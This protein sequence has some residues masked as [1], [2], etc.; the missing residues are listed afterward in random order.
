MSIPQKPVSSQW[1]DVA[2]FRILQEKGDKEQYVCASGITP[3]GTVHIGNFREIISVDL[4]VRALRN[5]GKKVRFIYSW[6]E[7]DVFR[8]VPKN[9]PDPQKLEKYLRWPITLVP[10]PWG[11]EDSYARAHEKEVE[12]LLPLVGIEPEFIYQAKEYN[13]CRYAEG[14]KKALEKREVIMKILNQYRK[15]PLASDWQPVSIFCSSC[16]RDTTSVSDWDGEYGLSYSCQS[17][18][19][20]EIMDFRKQGNVKLLWRIDWPMRWREEQV[21][22]EPAGKDHHSEGGSFDTAKQ[23]VKEVYDWQPPAT[24][25]YDFISIKGRGGKISSS[26]GEVI[27]LAD[28]LEVYQ[29]EV[30]RYMFAGTRPNTEFAISFDLDVIKIY[31]DYDKCERIYYGAE[32]MDEKKALREKRT[33]EYSQVHSVPD[34]MPLQVPFRHLTTLIQIHNGDADALCAMFPEADAESLKR[35]RTRAI[36]AWNWVRNFAP[37]DFRFSLRVDDDTTEELSDTELK[38]VKTLRETLEENW[39]N[40]DEKTLGETFYAI[41]QENGKEAKEVF[42]VIYKILLGKERGPRLASFILTVGK[43]KVQKILKRY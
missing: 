33:Y 14:I 6:D 19:H 42:P 36:C 8:K 26:S 23:I 34:K 25:Q 41:C 10:D 27:S 17:C 4:V 37:E 9:M 2:A 15:E 16:N 30:V 28:V 1:A 5:L 40:F 20:S 11:K 22:F 18:G 7:Y 43:E 29:P 32:K 38:I 21:D 31:E 3:S 39:D 35:L 24:F 12:K 13:S